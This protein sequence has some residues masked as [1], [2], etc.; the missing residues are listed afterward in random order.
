MVQPTIEGFP[1]PQWVPERPR[2]LTPGPCL[3]PFT[4]DWPIAHH[5]LFLPFFFFFLGDPRYHYSPLEDLG[6]KVALGS[7]FPRTYRVR[8]VWDSP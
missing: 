2:A 1:A 3:S 5:F 4:K 7:R 8:P 6:A